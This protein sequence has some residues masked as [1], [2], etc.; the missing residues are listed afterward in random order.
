[1]TIR[2]LVLGLLL[3]SL[4]EPTLATAVEHVRRGGIHLP[5]SRKEVRQ[6]GVRR[7]DTNTA[8]IG[9]GDFLDV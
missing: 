6:T 1:M 2:P 3:T 4:T 5:L 7:R 9:V 8:G